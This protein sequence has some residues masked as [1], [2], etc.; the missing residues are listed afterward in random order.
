MSPRN[1]I[2]IAIDGLRASALGAY[3]NTWHPTPGLDV[4]ASQSL[5]LDWMHCRTPTVAGFYRDVW[6]AGDQSLAE[7]I[8][9]A[10][11][12]TAITTDDAWA[13]EKAEAAGFA[14]IQRIE[15]DSAELAP[16]IADTQTA[17]LFAV[18]LDH[19][20]SW[21]MASWPTSRLLWIHAR[22]FHAA[23]DAPLD[24]RQTLLDE[25]DLAAP[26][27]VTP[28]V[29]AAIEDHDALLL[30]RAAYAA[31]TIVLDECVAALMAALTE[32]DLDQNTLIIFVGI[33]GYSL[34]EHGTIGGS[35]LYSELLH[36]P[37]LLRV[38][39][40]ESPPP[41]AA[42]LA[43]P[44]DVGVTLLD[45]FEIL[46]IPPEQGA[47]S[48]LSL[49]EAQRGDLERQLVIA[50]GEKGERVIRTPAWMLRQATTGVELFVKPDDR[51]EA[52]EVAAR[53]PEIAERLLAVLEWAGSKEAAPPLDNELI[54]P[55]R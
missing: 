13:G 38:P 31:Q 43:Q 44:V 25:D 48:L 34:G 28:P 7:R 9:A 51:W 11:V 53:C 3:G 27:F 17:R 5:V 18:A 54:L 50:S 24:L 4:L 45:W 35:S 52:N 39:A 22:G 49:A 26:T 33:R 1:A 21:K 40:L 29:V 15:I 47:S 36:V 41:R 8:G 12:E 37:C 14:E 16:V 30:H 55:V 32:L 19:L 23:W 2:V 10:G 42:H 20:A 6:Q 46:R